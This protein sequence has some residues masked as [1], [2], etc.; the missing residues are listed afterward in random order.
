M[1]SAPPAPDFNLKGIDGKQHKLGEYRSA[2]ALAVMFICN[3]CPASQL[4]EDRIKKMADDYRAK[5]VQFLAIQPNAVSAITQHEL[6][7]TDVDDSLDSM[8]IHAKFKNFN[9][10]YLYD[11]D[12]QHLRIST[13]PRTRRIFSSSTRSGSCATRAASTTAC[14]PITCASTMPAMLSTHWL[15]TARGVSAASGFRVQY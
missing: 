3:H 4:Y 2:K 6:N 1:R 11:G 9:F 7:Y 14:A 13:G 5:G 10:P 8:V 12:T 15:Q